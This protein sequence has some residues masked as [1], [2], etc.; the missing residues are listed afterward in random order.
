MGIEVTI[1]WEWCQ[2]TPAVHIQVL[3]E[4]QHTKNK[5]SNEKK[6]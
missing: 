5:F 3:E 4:L 6:V 2:V 1:A